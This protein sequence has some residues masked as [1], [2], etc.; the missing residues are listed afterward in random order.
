MGLQPVQIQLYQ[1][2]NLEQGSEF[3]VR[4]I[5]SNI[6]FKH[7]KG[8]QPFV[9]AKLKQ[10]DVVVEFKKWDTSKTLW[11][12]LVVPD[13]VVEVYGTL[14]LFGDVPQII[15][16]SIHCVNDNV[17]NYASIT[18]Y[19]P[20]DMYAYIVDV[21]KNMVYSPW[22]QAILLSVLE[23]YQTKLMYYPLS[24]NEH[25]E[26]GGFVN[27]LYRT[28]SPVIAR[29]T[30]NV[31]PPDSDIFH[32]PDCEVAIAGLILGKLGNLSIQ[33]ASPGSGEV[34]SIDYILKT[35]EGNNYNSRIAEKYLEIAKKNIEVT[36]DK[37]NPNYQFMLDNVMRKIFKIRH[38]ILALNG[39][40]KPA[41]L[42]AF[43]VQ[44]ASDSE[45]QEYEFY[46]IQKNLVSGETAP[47]N[48]IKDDHLI[49]G[50]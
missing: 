10:K 40:V 16:Q 5:L 23:E 32:I 1:I 49:V 17:E 14:D 24:D 22:L 12:A 6:E 19:N 9:R 25:S 44:N 35:S 27:W 4:G 46:K 29:T 31:T 2:K 36:I 7:S 33:T 47:F 28:L 50:L 34:T 15:C 38:C 20:A 3:I 37:T 30:Y 11:E 26:K 13:S 18:K 41:L 21:V 42:E 45:I 48:Q 43:I 39:L 8:N